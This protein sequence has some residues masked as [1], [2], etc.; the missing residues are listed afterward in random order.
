M[1]KTRRPKNPDC[2]N[3]IRRTYHIPPP[4]FH[5]R[6]CTPPEQLRQFFRFSIRVQ[7]LE[8]IKAQHK[9]VSDY[10]RELIARD[11]AGTE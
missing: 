5:C 7:D 8:K 3:C 10:L 11:L 2:M 9:N 6:R 4:A 1:S